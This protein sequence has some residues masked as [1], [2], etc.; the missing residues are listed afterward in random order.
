MPSTLRRPP[1]GTSPSTR[2]PSER[3]TVRR[4][5]KRV[6]AVTRLAAASGL[7]L[8]HYGEGHVDQCIER[9]LAREKASDPHGLARL[10]YSDPEVRERFRRSVAVSVSGMFRDP[11]QFDLIE[12]ELTRS[13]RLSP[14]L[15]VWS[16]G[17][18]DG[19]EAF[20]A[21]L[22][23]ERLGALDGS[24]VLGSDLLEENVAAANRCGDDTAPRHVRSHVRFECR[25]V[26]SQPAPGG[27]WHLIL[28]RNLAIYLTR[29]AKTKLHERLA[30]ALT[31]GGVL[32]L[33]KSERLSDPASLGLEPVANHLYRRTA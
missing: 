30:G 25:D 3:V 21:A 31:H 24:R 19:S 13:L 17:C 8:E 33:G 11:D 29:H 28:C 27:S 32:A 9:A 7:R 26:V 2:A 5:P 10:I 6:A 16:A 15:R 23:L 14:A 20:S 22:L 12:A 18:A 4:E 1:A